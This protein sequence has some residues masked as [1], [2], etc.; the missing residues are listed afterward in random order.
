M[1]NIV[2][3]TVLL[4]EG[5]FIDVSDLPDNVVQSNSA[6]SSIH[7]A[8]TAW[9][10]PSPKEPISGRPA[11]TSLKEIV[12]QETERVE[13]EMIQRAL[14]DKQ[15]NVTQAARQLGISRKSLQIKMKEFKLREPD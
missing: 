7:I 5:P 11:A 2:E 3:R 9:A 14:N 15:G 10:K 6:H 8:Q 12:R 4:A 1:E 13:R